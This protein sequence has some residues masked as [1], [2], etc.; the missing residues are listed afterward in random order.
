MTIYNK[1]SPY[2]NTP[3]K[4]GYLDVATFRSFPSQDDDVLYQVSKE[5]EYRPD[6][7]AYEI[8]KDSSLWW[9]FA[10][11]NPSIIKDPIFD[12]EAG[13]VIYLPKISTLQNSLGI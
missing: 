10:V 3:L 9:V 8:Y 4:N 5:Y 11:R 1:T 2:Y 6:L 13:V 12:L 7:L